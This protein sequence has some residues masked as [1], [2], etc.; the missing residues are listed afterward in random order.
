M[1]AIESLPQ[2]DT[3]PGRE[4]T[5]PQ[6][7]ANGEK[8]QKATQSMPKKATRPLTRI[9]G[10]IV[11]GPKVG[12]LTLLQ[13]LLGV[14]PNDSKLDKERIPMSVAMPYAPPPGMPTWN[15]IQLQVG[16]LRGQ[17]LLSR[18]DFLIVVVNPDL[19]KDEAQ[20]HA[21]QMIQQYMHQ[22]G[23]S[24]AEEYDGGLPN[25][26]LAPVCIC[27]LVN[28][29]DRAHGKTA[30]ARLEILMESLQVFLLGILE[31]Y[32]IPKDRLLLQII[33]AS[34]K[35]G[36]SLETIRSFIYRTYVQKKR[37]ALEAQL[38]AVTSQIDNFVETPIIQAQESRVPT[39]ETKEL[40][41]ITPAKDHEGESS[42]IHTLPRKCDSVKGDPKQNRPQPPVQSTASHATNRAE[43]AGKSS[44]RQIYPSNNQ[45]T[46][47]GKDALEAFLASDDSD[48]E[49]QHDPTAKSKNSRA[50]TK[51]D[52]KPAF[53]SGDDD[54][55]DDDFFY[56][57]R[58]NFKVAK[59]TSPH[60]SF[61]SASTST[62]SSSDDGV[63]KVRAKKRQGNNIVVNKEMEPTLVQ[64]IRISTESQKDPVASRTKESLSSPTSNDVA[65]DSP[66]P[67][68]VTGTNEQDAKNFH[69]TT[70][71]DN[72]LT[73][74]AG[75]LESTITD[76][77][78]H[79]EP[80]LRP[81][82]DQPKIVPNDQPVAVLNSLQSQND[83]NSGIGNHLD[84]ISAGRSTQIAATP[85]VNGDDDSSGDDDFFVNE[86]SPT[87]KGE[88]C[89]DDEASDD[90][91]F[92]ISD[93]RRRL[94]LDSNVSLG[95]SN[96]EEKG[97]NQTP[98][99]ENEGPG[100]GSSDAKGESSTDA[101]ALPS[102]FAADK[103]QE[104]AAASSPSIVE[105]R[106]T[107]ISAAALAAIQ[108]A[109][110]QA[111]EMLLQPTLQEMP[112]EVISTKKAKK[113][114]KEK[115]SK[116][117]RSKKKKERSAEDMDDS[118]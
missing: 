70:D 67:A 114:K 28:F 108:A 71:D 74:K 65:S 72:C 80:P 29:R 66:T 3:A 55:D 57:E 35:T 15:R 50:R 21:H 4:V 51:R 16:R 40:E 46:R 102:A 116:K 26:S 20:N 52:S 24:K 27:I 53:P 19:P 34:T 104:K 7:N 45:E 77:N 25:N 23:H 90:D 1:G 79:D 88:P 86:T 112:L 82:P 54:D 11:G 48:D 69:Q 91:E 109:Q 18:V 42:K 98:H 43:R 107:G 64:K 12:K 101:M 93:D 110:A 44:R 22:L 115:K 85:R 10:A 37:E 38:K 92:I 97:R 113:Q 31:P 47:I 73:E 6:T 56:D 87:M 14:D 103:G 105:A 111:E 58:G 2:E 62:S 49:K 30:T 99:S 17:T 81:K 13:R 61:S 60:D 83:S 117:D 75:G 41:S 76:K 39:K 63:D 68:Q 95:S 33:S 78:N 36:Q 106:N 118:S 9:S 89:N 32:T 59:D 94:E 96:A 5:E 8:P 100:S 84:D